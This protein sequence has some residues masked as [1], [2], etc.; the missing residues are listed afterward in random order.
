M[1]FVQESS[2]R[3]HLRTKAAEHREEVA[4][5]EAPPL[6]VPGWAW[7]FPSPLPLP[8]P[9]LRRAGEEPGKKA[10]PLPLGRLL[11][12]VVVV[13]LLLLLLLLPLLAAFS[14]PSSAVFRLGACGA[15]LPSP[16][17]A[18]PLSELRPPPRSRRAGE[19]QR[20]V[21][22]CA[23]PG[24]EPEPV[25]DDAAPSLPP[26][27]SAA[28][29]GAAACAPKAPTAPRFLSVAGVPRRAAP[30]GSH[31][32]SAPQGLLR[33]LLLEATPSWA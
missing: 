32:V 16:G 20:V 24:P 5:G 14:G 19:E 15:S 6:P 1:H 7:L 13:L 17:W 25:P 27:L 18:W 2:Y 23:V 30:V 29:G 33:R 3:L 21:A 10:E 8:S 22:G 4:A 31:S 28:P 26:L 12:V 11:L 9:Q